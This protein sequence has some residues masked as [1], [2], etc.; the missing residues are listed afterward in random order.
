MAYDW[1]PEMTKE[2]MRILL[3]KE[4]LLP[5]VLKGYDVTEYMVRYDMGEDEAVED[6]AAKPAI[7]D[8]YKQILA[9]QTIEQ[10]ADNP[11][12]RPS[13]C[14]SKS[15]KLVNQETAKTTF[16]A[17]KGEDY[18]AIAKMAVQGDYTGVVKSSGGYYVIYRADKIY[19][20]SSNTWNE[21]INSYNK[22]NVTYGPLTK[23]IANYKDTSNWFMGLIVAIAK[24]AC[25]EDVYSPSFVWGNAID[26]ATGLGLQGVLVEEQITDYYG[27]CKTQFL[28]DAK[29]PNQIIDFSNFYKT[30][31]TDG[32]GYFQFGGQ[33]SV[34]CHYHWSWTFSKAEYETVVK[35]GQ[36]VANGQDEVVQASMWPVR[37]DLNV[38]IVGVGSVVTNATDPPGKDAGGN[39]STINCSNSGGV[40]SL[41]YRTGTPVTLTATPGSG[42]K[43]E[44]IL[45]SGNVGNCASVS[46]THLTLPTKRIV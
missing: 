41:N 37:Y 36:G 2:S 38:N 21:F 20:G 14:L 25:P 27:Q 24:A 23:I 46:Y 16:F 4:R 19:G 28:S 5:L 39:V 18:A 22:D 45:W 40:C 43:I 31:T 17:S 44:G 34:E 9:G 1:T 10:L 13:K 7:E 3:L 35:D 12:C 6:P 42:Y 30:R 8:A 32:D 33:A 29:D 15:L 11:N 26:S